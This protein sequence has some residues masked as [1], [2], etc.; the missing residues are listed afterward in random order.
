[1]IK[2]KELKGY[3]HENGIHWYWGNE[4]IAIVGQ[5]NGEIEWCGRRFSYPDAVVKA[6]RDRRSRAAGRWMIEAKR[7]SKS[8][9]QGSIVISINGQEIMEFNDDKMLQNG[10]WI[11]TIPDSE[12]GKLVISAFWHKFDSIYHYS[13]RAKKIFYKDWR[14]NND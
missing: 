12:I 9:T 11:S 7:I 4:E 5:N 14:V 6:I 2:G 8:V 13:D 10:E 1:M 3:Q